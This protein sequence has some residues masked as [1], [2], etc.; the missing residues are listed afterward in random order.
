[1]F[2]GFRPRAR[3]LSERAVMGFL[4]HVWLSRRST[5]SEH[6]HHPD[7]EVMAQSSEHYS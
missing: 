7:A 5:S 1:M 4:L 2:I 6:A 3:R